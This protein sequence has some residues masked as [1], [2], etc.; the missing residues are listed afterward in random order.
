MT[1]K[2]KSFLHAVKAE[3]K[4]ISWPTRK[5]IVRSTIIVF[6]TIIVFAVII[7][8]IDTALYQL[9]IRVFVGSWYFGL[10]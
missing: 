3:M 7:G 2:I 9:I 1:N 8:V 10:T 6:I 5:E 4:K